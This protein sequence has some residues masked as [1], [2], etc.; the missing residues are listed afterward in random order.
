MFYENC[1]EETFFFIVL[2]LLYCCNCLDVELL[3][4]FGYVDTTHY[5]R[6][7]EWYILGCI[8]TD[9]TNTDYVT[10]CVTINQFINIYKQQ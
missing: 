6:L 3:P 2:E 7:S 4:K 9:K 5:F 8:L 1:M 10:D